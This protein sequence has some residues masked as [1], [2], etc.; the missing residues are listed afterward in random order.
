MIWHEQACKKVAKWKKRERN[1]NHLHKQKSYTVIAHLPQSPTVHYA[2]AVPPWPAS[3]CASWFH[4]WFVL[5]SAAVAPSTPPESAVTP[6]GARCAL[7]PQAP[8]Y[9]YDPCGKNQEQQSKAH[10]P[11]PQRK[12]RRHYAAPML[13]HTQRD[14]SQHFIHTDVPQKTKC[15]KLF[16]NTL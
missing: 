1:S 2:S 16:C 4:F 3:V 10:T 12:S 9:Q 7:R 6:R 13:N 8:M 14:A 5:G 11:M 15:K